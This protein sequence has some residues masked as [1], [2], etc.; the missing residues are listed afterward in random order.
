[1]EIF[2][3]WGK[4]KKFLKTKTNLFA[5]IASETQGDYISVVLFVL[6]GYSLQGKMQLPNQA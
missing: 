4:K 6:V 3:S 2:V 5:Y 1:V